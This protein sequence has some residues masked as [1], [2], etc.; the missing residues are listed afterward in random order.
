MDSANSADNALMNSG[1]STSTQRARGRPPGS[2]KK[3]STPTLP[4]FNTVVASSSTAKS[5]KTVPNKSAKKQTK[6]GNSG[7]KS[8]G[9][10]QPEEFVRKDVDVNSSERIVQRIE[11][12]KERPVSVEDV[13]ALANY[14]KWSKIKDLDKGMK[15]LISV[16]DQLLQR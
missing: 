2:K 3:D 9:K 15:A 6:V 16:R 7:S 4:D 12:F 5:E 1:G 14:R 13:I 11:E 10:H 8:K